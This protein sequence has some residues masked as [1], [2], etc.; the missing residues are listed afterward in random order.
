MSIS[1]SGFAATA[2]GAALVALHGREHQ[3]RCDGP[4]GVDADGDC[5]YVHQTLAPGVVSLIGGVAL[6]ATGVT[7]L[8]VGRRQAEI[9]VAATHRKVMVSGRF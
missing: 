6:S 8:V 2:S 7:L 1:R 5:R 3:G 4:Q 9:G